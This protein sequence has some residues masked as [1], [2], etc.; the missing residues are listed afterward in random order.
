MKVPKACKNVEVY[1]ISGHVEDINIKFSML[2]VNPFAVD[3]VLCTSFFNSYWNAQ[4]TICV[5]NVE[6]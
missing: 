1:S 4:S 5:R 3:D 2:T 6:G